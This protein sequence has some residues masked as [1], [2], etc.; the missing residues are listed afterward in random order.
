MVKQLQARLPLNCCDISILSNRMYHKNYV[1][2]KWKILKKLF[3]QLSK[4]R[5]LSIII[6]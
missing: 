5:L 1:S 6:I 4:P 2:N 3:W